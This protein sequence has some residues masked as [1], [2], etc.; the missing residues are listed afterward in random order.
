MNYTTALSEAHQWKDKVY[1]F[2]FPAIMMIYG[3]PKTGKTHFLLNFLEEIKHKFDEIICY[4]GTKDGSKAFLDLNKTKEK[5]SIKILFNY[6]EDDLRKWYK[7]LEDKQNKLIEAK[8]KPLN[9]LIVGDDI[10]SFRNFM[11]TS[12][13]NPS[14]LE[15]ICANYRHVNLSMIITSQRYMQV[16]PALRCLN[17][18]YMI[19]FGM[20]LKDI[21]KVGE[22]HETLYHNKN[23]IVG[24]FFKIKENGLGHAL[25]IN[26]DAFDKERFNH[27]DTNT[28]TITVIE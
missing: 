21:Q 1:G 26:N 18:K 19:V 23:K 11:A 5:P 20:G 12:R 9:V 27:L 24:A 16:I 28:K 2:S 13:S 7:K 3:T 25:F 15:E 4:L 22:E 8:K 6:S 14:I 10:L 17:F